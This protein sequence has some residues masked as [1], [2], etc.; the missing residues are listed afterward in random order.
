[1]INGLEGIPGSGKS[2]EAVVHHVLEAL[3]EGRKVITNL[4]LLVDQFAAIDNG[5]RALIE[6]RIRPAPVRGTWDATRMDEDGNGNAFELFDDGHTDQAPH[7]AILFATVWCYYSTWKHP[8]PK[9]K[10]QGPLYVIDECHVAMP[11]VGTPKEVVEWFKLH[12]H[13]G[14]DVLLMT[15]SFRDIN[16][17]IARLMGMLVKVRKADILGKKDHYIRKVHGGYRGAVISTQE[18]KYL[19]QMFPLYK[20]HTQG[21]AVLE[22]VARDVSPMIV[23]FRRFT[24]GFWVLTIGV[25]AWAFWPKDKPVKVK[26]AQLVQAAPAQ[27]EALAAPVVVQPIPGQQAPQVVAQQVDVYPEPYKDHKLHVTGFLTMGAKSTHTFAV[28]QGT[29]VLAT[30]STQDLER[31]GYSVRVLSECAV[32]LRFH[33][34]QRTAV[35]DLPAQPRFDGNKSNGV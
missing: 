5:Y 31:A 20:S 21:S 22:S 12:R 19:P 3:K 18:R 7:D 35:C 9:K 34:S 8:D 27:A 15:Q 24:L 25:C 11:S 29:A 33:E 16:Q 23:K 28:V 14:A 26:P 4:P 2:Y 13:F 1:M 17:P 30:V 6:V 32:V 10:G